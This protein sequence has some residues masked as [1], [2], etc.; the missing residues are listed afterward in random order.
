[1]RRRCSECHKIITQGYV[2]HDGEKYYC[3]N[4]CLYQNFTP[5]EWQEIYESEQGYY[6]EWEGED[7]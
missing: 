7:R 4:Y 5:N 3:S 2:L 1:M 6:T